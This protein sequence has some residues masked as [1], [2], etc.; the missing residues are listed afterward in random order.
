MLITKPET[1]LRTIL[2][3][4]GGGVKGLTHVG[5]WRAMRELGVVVDEIIG[6]SIGGLVGALVAGG[7]GVDE[8]SARAAALKRTDIVALNRWAVLLNGIRQPSVFHDEP[9][10]AFIDAALPVQ[11]FGELSIPLALNVAD[12]GSGEQVWLGA[13]GHEDVALG[14]AVYATC[15]LPV[16]YP[17]AAIDGRLYVDGGVVDTL[18]LARAAERGAE[19]IIAVDAGAIGFGDPNEVLERGIVGVHHRVF[20]IMAAQR[21]R[22]ELSAWSGPPVTFIRPRLEG[23][24]T[25]DFGHTAYFLEE[26]YRAAR[27]AL[28]AAG[29]TR[30]EQERE[31]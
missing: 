9:L 16:F 23:Y 24:D 19:R 22:L 14:Q 20:Q 11:T 13:G 7:M 15:A 12:L 27:E 30:A 2:V 28:E 29:F 10:R 4:G 21:E 8:L 1:R 18:P 25:F 6:T 5:A 3:L 26:G 31:A 17:P